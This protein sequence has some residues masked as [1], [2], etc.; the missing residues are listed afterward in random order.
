[1]LAAGDDLGVDG[2]ETN[3]P[4]LE[5][6][7]AIASRFPFIRRFSSILS[8]S[9]PRMS[10]IRSCSHR[11]GRG[12]RIDRKEVNGCPMPGVPTVEVFL[13]SS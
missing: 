5:E 13:R 10:A 12:T 4:T 6:R 9:E 8:S 3:E 2:I 7:R 1:M 11:V